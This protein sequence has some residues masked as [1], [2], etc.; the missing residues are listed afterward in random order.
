M[1][2]ARPS[3]SN[4]RGPSSGGRGG[5]GGGRRGGGGGG[6]RRGGGGVIRVEEFHIYVLDV[7][8]GA[9][10]THVRVSNRCRSRLR[11]LKTPEREQVHEEIKGKGHCARKNCFYLS[12]QLL[13]GEL[14]AISSAFLVG[15]DY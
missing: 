2:S 7:N 15:H 1:P 12:V 3:N 9:D 5:R 10:G 4:R 6:R 13:E 11:R 14:N 8:D